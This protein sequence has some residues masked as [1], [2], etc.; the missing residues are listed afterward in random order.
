MEENKED[1]NLFPINFMVLKDY[2]WEQLIKHFEKVS[3]ALL[4]LDPELKLNL[5]YILNPFPK[6]VVIGSKVLHEGFE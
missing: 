4:L 1:E 6:N 3:D 2:Y 5:E